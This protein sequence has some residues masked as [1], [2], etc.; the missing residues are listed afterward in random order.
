MEGGRANADVRVA[1]GRR[2]LVDHTTLE[3][4]GALREAGIEPVVLKGPAI[5]RWLYDQPGERSYDDADILLA[6]ADV[7]RAEEVLT[8]LG[9]ARLEAPPRDVPLPPGRSSHADTWRRTGDGVDIDLHR[10][11]HH[12]EHVPAQQ[13]W[14]EVWGDHETIQ[15][16]D[17][18]VAVPAVRVRALHVVLHLQ[19]KDVPGSRAWVDLERAVDRV[20]LADWRAAVELADRFGIRDEVGA[21]L[22]LVAGGRELAEQLGLDTTP[23]DALLQ[24]H[25]RHAP[26]IPHLVRR[27]QGRPVGEAVRVVGRKASPARV[28][29]VTPPGPDGRTSLVRAYVVQLG[30][31]PGAV[32]DWLQY[33][34]DG[35]R[36]LR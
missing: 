2:M 18:E 28:R 9:Y 20:D 36:S 13:V 7:A 23:P 22:A 21:L 30:R 27:V 3:V 26:A 16:F 6:P 34:R 32:R 4:V 1:V 10:C 35:G 12:T 33:R 24:E 8:A 19:P 11:L 17:T 29:A 25:R 5:A 31:L 15:V 14:D